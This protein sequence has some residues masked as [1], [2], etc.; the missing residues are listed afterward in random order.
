MTW[1]EIAL[2]LTLKALELG[3]IPKKTDNLF[4]GNDPTQEATKYAA[5]Q[6][7]TFFTEVYNQIKNS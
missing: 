7:S 1:D 2:Q 5:D 4:T 6:I 3:Y